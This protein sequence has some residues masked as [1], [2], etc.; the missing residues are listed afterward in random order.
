MGIEI[1][2]TKFSLAEKMRRAAARAD[3]GNRIVNPPLTVPPAWASGTAYTVGSVVTNDTG[4]TYLCHTGGTSAGSGGPTGIGTQLITDNTAKWVYIGV[5]PISANAPETPLYTYAAGDTA[6]RVPYPQLTQRWSIVANPNVFTVRRADPLVATSNPSYST[7]F[8]SQT[9]AA[10][11][12]LTGYNDGKLTLGWEVTFWTD[13][14]VV[15]LSSNNNS[16]TPVRISVDDRYYS[17]G[18]DIYGA[19]SPSHRMLD[20]TAA[21]GRE[22]RKITMEG[23]GN[24]LFAGIYTATTDTVW[25]DNTADDIK[26]VLF[27]SS[28]EGGAAA[29]PIDVSRGWPHQFAQLMGWKNLY[30]AGIGGTGYL[31]TSSGTKYNYRQHINDAIARQPSVVLIGGPVND[32]SETAAA[33]QAEATLLYQEL[34]AGLPDALIVA[35]GST[36]RDSATNNLRAETAVRDAVAAMNDPYIKFL[37]VMLDT[38]GQWIT[39]ANFSTYVAT[40]DSVHPNQAGIDYYARR[41]ARSFRDVIIP[42]I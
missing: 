7:T 15:A 35:L 10:T 16:S 8:W 24:A 13:A 6:M 14:P 1:K 37:P 31:S 32:Q 39:A 5:C 9:E 22:A 21:G 26:C 33:I 42:S 12:G 34:R 40:G 3:N 27:G 41:Y 29:F 18:A 36:V 2:T 17:M 23:Y 11:G 38:P 30:N 20:F 25:A 28:L 19:G 4:K